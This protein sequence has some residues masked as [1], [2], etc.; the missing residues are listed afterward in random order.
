[1]AVD[2]KLNAQLQALANSLPDPILVIDYEGR[3]VAVLGGSERSC[4]DSPHPLLG[5][6][7]QDVLPE[8]KWRYFL[9]VVCKA[10]D[11]GTLQT[12]EYQLSSNQVEGTENNGP[13]GMQ[14]FQGRVY[15][16]QTSPGQTPTAV[17]LVI[18]ITEQKMLEERLRSLAQTDDLTGVHNRR[19]FMD[20]L[21][22]EFQI[23]R[24]R[25]HDLSLISIDVDHFKTIND[26][27]GHSQG[28]KAL[29]HLIKT[30]Q[31]HL[32]AG[33][34]LARIG[35]EEFAILCPMT[36]RQQARTL[37]ERICRIIFATPLGTS[38][39]SIEMTASL[40]VAT[41]NT[42]AKSADCLLTRA[43]EALYRAKREGRNRVFCCWDSPSLAS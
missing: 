24:R 8:V 33:D 41:M 40:G 19:Y 35:G 38:H 26:R 6:T 25:N 11:T 9:Q 28:D 5:R 4:Y 22:R 14:W 18:N 32:R 42:R 13:S 3:Y 37:A 2:E 34:V 23:A 10:I 21:Y 12:C 43:D 16:V 36:D 29:Q 15:P 20:V 27:Y 30:I 39:G 17:W 1:M 31:G 7:M